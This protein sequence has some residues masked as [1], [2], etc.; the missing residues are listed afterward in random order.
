MRGIHVLDTHS[1]SEQVNR[2][3]GKEPTFQ[4]SST[5]EQTK[6]SIHRK[7]FVLLKWGNFEINFILKIIQ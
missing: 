5:K 4:V 3:M 1:V 6:I 7:E 2:G